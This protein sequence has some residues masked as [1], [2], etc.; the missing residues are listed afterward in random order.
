M[1]G[2]TQTL[3]EIEESGTSSDEPKIVPGGPPWVGLLVVAVVI[4]AFGTH[5]ILATNAERDEQA[6]RV[7]A[8]QDRMEVL[9]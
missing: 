5:Q 4:L 2:E 3:Y 7:R 8:A 6:Q 1:E 9:N